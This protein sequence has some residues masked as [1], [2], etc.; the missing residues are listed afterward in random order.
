M[1]E[2]DQTSLIVSQRG[3]QM[4]VCLSQSMLSAALIFRSFHRHGLIHSSHYQKHGMVKPCGCTLLNI[5]GP[6]LQFKWSS[7]PAVE[8]PS[9]L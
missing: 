4:L 3:R 8:L 5:Y 1:F 9:S 7:K 6:V 2:F